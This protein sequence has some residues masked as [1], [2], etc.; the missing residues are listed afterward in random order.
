M[1]A[2]KHTSLMHTARMHG[3]L[4]PLLDPSMH[5]SLRCRLCCW[6][7]GTWKSQWITRKLGHKIRRK[8]CVTSLAGLFNWRYIKMSPTFCPM[9]TC[10]IKKK[11]RDHVGAKICGR[12]EIDSMSPSYL[13]Q[14][15]YFFTSHRYSELCSVQN[16]FSTIMSH[17]YPLNW[18][19][20]WDEWAGTV[21]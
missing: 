3:F 10:S 5:G 17:T 13:V 16:M 1:F 11:A 12:L 7:F 14:S 8:K 20:K 19:G 18:G 9:E 2:S 15:C 21:S 4:N 6:L